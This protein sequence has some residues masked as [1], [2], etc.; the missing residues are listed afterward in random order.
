[1]NRWGLIILSLSGIAA[2]QDAPQ[3]PAADAPRVPAAPGTRRVRSEEKVV[4]DSASAEES[5]ADGARFFGGVRIGVGIPP[6]SNGVAPLQGVEIGVSARR[7]IGFGLHVVTMQNPPAV[8]SLNIP[9]ASWGIGALADVRM[10][11]QTVDPLTLYATLSGGFLAGPG[12]D[13][14]GNAVLPML[15]PGFGARVK[16]NDTLYVAFEFGAASFFIPFVAL[17]FGWEP[18]RHT[19]H[20][21]H[22]G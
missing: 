20:V 10:Y 5:W 6:G 12:T 1:M 13:G 16:L 15:N 17:S 19:P 2:A 11:F 22:E 4:D 3:E 14:N 7:G 8:T 21:S 9:K 18:P